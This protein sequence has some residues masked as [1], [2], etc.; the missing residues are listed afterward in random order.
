MGGWGDYIVDRNH[1]NAQLPCQSFRQCRPS[2]E[3][4]RAE[5]ISALPIHCQGISLRV[6]RNYGQ[7]RSKGRFAAKIH[8]GPGIDKHKRRARCRAIIARYMWILI[9]QPCSL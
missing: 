4:R 3:N 2:R 1:A 6:E 8:F 9:E 7:H 5:R